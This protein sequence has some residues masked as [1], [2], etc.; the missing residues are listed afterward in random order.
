[1]KAKKYIRLHGQPIYASEEIYTLPVHLNPV[2]LA[3]FVML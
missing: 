2:S 1:M 3:V